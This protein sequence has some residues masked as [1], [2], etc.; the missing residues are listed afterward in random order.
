MKARIK[1]LKLE[2]KAG[3][4]KSGNP[5][6]LDFLHFLDL[7]NFDKISVMIPKDQVAIIGSCIG[8]DGTIDL[9]MDAKTEKLQFSAF[10]LAA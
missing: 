1:V 6:D 4:A 7:D 2:N 10:K 8:K 5:Y 3:I 9:G